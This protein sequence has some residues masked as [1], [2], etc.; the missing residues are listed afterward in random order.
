M[1]YLRGVVK[2][3]LKFIEAYYDKDTEAAEQR[4]YE[5]LLH[6]RLK[7]GLFIHRK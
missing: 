1:S 2:K 7:T 4:S 3:H 5:N 6:R